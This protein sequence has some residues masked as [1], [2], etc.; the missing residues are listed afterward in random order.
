MDYHVQYKKLLHRLDPKKFSIATTKK[1]AS[2]YLRIFDP[3]DDV[4]PSIEHIISD[5]Y[6]VLTSIKYIVEDEGCIIPDVKNVKNT[7]KGRQR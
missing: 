6:D 2:Y 1:G 7:R 5:T 3:I 4:A